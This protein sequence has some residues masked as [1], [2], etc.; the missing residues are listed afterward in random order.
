MLR[1]EA[2]KQRKNVEFASAKKLAFR[3]RSMLKRPSA[4]AN[5]KKTIHK[6]RHIVFRER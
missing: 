2:T 1:K 6:A 5:V 4:A 3:G